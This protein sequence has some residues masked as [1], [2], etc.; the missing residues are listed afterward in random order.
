MSLYA[1]LIDRSEIV[2]KMLSHCL[3]YF[4]VEVLRFDSLEASQSHFSEKK[5]DIVFIDWEI[6]KGD[7][8]AV[9][10]AIEEMKPVPV[11]M[12]CRAGPN[13]SVD[14]ISS[15][16]IPHKIKKPLDPKT[17]RDILVKL[18]PQVAEFKIHSFLKF[19]KN[20]EEKEKS[21]IVSGLK[22]TQQAAD[23]SEKNFQIP[24]QSPQKSI[25]SDA[26]KEKA[27]SFLKQTFSGIPTLKDKTEAQRSHF[28]TSP[29]ASVQSS[30]N[31]KQNL[32]QKQKITEKAAE[33]EQK[34]SSP[35]PPPLIRK[36]NTVTGEM[37]INKENINIDENTQ[38]AFAPMAIKSSVSPMEQT[39]ISANAP[40]NEKDILRVLKK[41]RDSLEFQELMERVLSEYAKKTVASIL[42][43][44]K[45]TDLLRQPLTE[46][47]ESQQ[48]RRLVEQQVIQYVQKQLP[49]VIKEIVEQEIKKIIGD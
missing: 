35:K 31:Q 9:Y 5:P 15:S 23:P 28:I 19:P 22:D 32:T 39:P 42:Q 11:V 6:K 41:Y 26:A 46:F 25:L 34:K 33:F 44:D 49:L 30:L 10:S 27:Q 21:S 37:Q 20:K 29:K 12:L 48:F 14:S 17:V 4:P 36:E 18:V 16:Q 43:E 8:A 24:V 1:A 2:Q 45:V 3:H 47:K 13:V 40:L 38:N 7:T